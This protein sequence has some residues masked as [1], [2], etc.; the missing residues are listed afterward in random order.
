MWLFVGLIQVPSTSWKVIDQQRL[1]ISRDY[2][3]RPLSLGR[4]VL[5]QKT[6]LISRDAGLGMDTCDAHLPTRQKFQFLLT[7]PSPVPFCFFTTSTVSENVKFHLDHFTV[8]YTFPPKNQ[9]DCKGA[10]STSYLLQSQQITVKCI[11]KDKK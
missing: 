4:V 3:S 1:Q 5:G 6:L 10:N 2:I 9:C 7:A 11:F 8:S